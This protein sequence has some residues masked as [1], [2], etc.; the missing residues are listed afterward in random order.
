MAAKLILKPPP[1]DSPGAR[2]SSKAF[3]K[4]RLSGDKVFGKISVRTATN[5]N[6]RRC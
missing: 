3:G 6:R 4:A 5:G 1:D 2:Y